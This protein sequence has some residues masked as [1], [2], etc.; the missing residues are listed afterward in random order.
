M[1]KRGV[2]NVQMHFA[3]IQNAVNKN[4][5]QIIGYDPNKYGDLAEE[6]FNWK[7]IE[8]PAIRSLLKN[9]LSN[10]LK[11]LDAGCGEGRTIKLLIELGVEEKNIYG[12]DIMEELISRIKDR[13][14]TA[15]FVKDDFSANGDLYPNDFFDLITSNMVLDYLDDNELEKAME[16]IAK[17]LK[18][19]GLFLF[20][21]SHPIREVMKI[22]KDLRYYLCREK[23]EDI[24]PW[25]ATVEYNHRP[26]SDYVNI[27]INNGLNIVSLVEPTVEEE[28]KIDKE[29]YEEYTKYPSRLFVMA[30]K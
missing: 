4:M 11:I 14:P 17:W 28:G 16:N 21:L 27:L 12:V 7:H 9:K 30:R 23:W 5:K 19:G 22:K 6:F 20:G 1:P 13:F 24:T 8:K 15:N 18:K 26:I 25:G 10:D 2:L 3:G 29:K